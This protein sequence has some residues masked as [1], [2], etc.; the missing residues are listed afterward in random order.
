MQRDVN[1]TCDHDVELMSI[2]SLLQHGVVALIMRNTAALLLLLCLHVNGEL[3]S[4]ILILDPLHDT[5]F[6]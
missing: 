4:F 1:T 5:D 2:F 3:G 6:S